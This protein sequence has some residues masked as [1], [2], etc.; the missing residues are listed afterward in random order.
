M[1][2][3]GLE[4]SIVLNVAAFGDELSCGWLRVEKRWAFSVV[5][6]KCLELAAS[7]NLRVLA[8]FIE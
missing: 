8:V 3:M 6:V 7:P 2:Y 1:Y 5:S 4:V